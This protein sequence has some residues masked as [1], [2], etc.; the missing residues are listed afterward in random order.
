MFYGKLSV[1][2]TGLQAGGAV[3]Q[4]HL[5]LNLIHRGPARSSVQVMQRR[6]AVHFV[7]LLRPV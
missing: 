7:L 2:Q 3:L 5:A 6:T 4:L 1:K